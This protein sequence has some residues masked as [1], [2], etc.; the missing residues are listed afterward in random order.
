MHLPESEQIRSAMEQAAARRERRLQW[1][2]GSAM[3]IAV[4]VTIA[5]GAFLFF[6][7][8]YR[9]SAGSLAQPRSQP[10]SSQCSP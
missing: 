1:L 9:S 5:W 10:E 2:D 7:A 4:A 6:W 8:T 3:G